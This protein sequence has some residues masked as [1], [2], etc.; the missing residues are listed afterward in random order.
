M[1]GCNSAA[2]LPKRALQFGSRAATLQGSAG[3]KSKGSDT[4]EDL[5]SN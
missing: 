3:G 1:L 4:I 2:S 5:L